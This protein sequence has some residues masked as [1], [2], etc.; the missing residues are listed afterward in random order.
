MCALAQQ[1]PQRLRLLRERPLRKPGSANDFFEWGQI[2]K[3][4]TPLRKVIA[5]AC[6]SW[7]AFGV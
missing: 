2:A 7:S 6:G 5:N 4:M 3:P 1:G